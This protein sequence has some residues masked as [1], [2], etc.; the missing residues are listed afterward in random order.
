LRWAGRR[1]H[2]LGFEAFRHG[3][4]FLPIVWALD[5]F[6]VRVGIGRCAQWLATYRLGK[7]GDSSVVQPTKATKAISDAVTASGR[8]HHPLWT[9]NRLPDAVAMA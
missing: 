7:V 4:S 5:R 2:E 8:R 3:G 1:S 9:L 6:C